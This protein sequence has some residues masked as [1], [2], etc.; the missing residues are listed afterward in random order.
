MSF[1]KTWLFQNKYIGSHIKNFSHLLLSGGKVSVPNEQHKTLCKYY[2]KDIINGNINYITEM[3]TSVFKFHMDIDLLNETPIEIETIL[4]Y[5]KNIQECIKQFISWKNI[6]N[7]T[8]AKKYMMIISISPKQTKNKNNNE[9]IKYGIHLNWPY[10]H[11]DTYIASIL[12]EGCIQYLTQIF[13]ERHDNN[14]W[15]DVIDKTVYT[16]NGLR[17]IFSDK[18]IACPNCKGKKNHGKDPEKINIC[19]VCQDVGKVPANRIYEILS[20]LD[21]N[22]TIMEKELLLL[23]TKSFENILKCVE[24]LSIRCFNKKTNVEIQEPFPKWYKVHNVILKVKTE[25]IDKKQVNPIVKHH[26]TETSEIKKKF[27]ILE[28]FGID[29][30]RYKDIEQF[31]KD[32][33]PS[34]YED[35]KII[36]ILLCGKKNSKTRSYI[37]R[38]D[39]KFC[40]N[41]Q[42]EHNSNH[43]YFIITPERMHQRCFCRC[44]IIRPSG[45]KCMNY[46]DKGKILST[47]LKEKLFPEL[48]ENLNEQRQ[49]IQYNPNKFSDIHPLEDV[50]ERFVKYF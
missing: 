43:I 44:D 25:K 29:D 14:K 7:E 41:I 45:I 12:R 10:L 9:Y 30:S 33:L 24:L 27:A 48:I 31:M 4:T 15:D 37:I 36:E 6:K 38:T 32:F 49:H 18:A 46:M 35:I 13:G 22:N 19:C 26:L 2:A 16:N 39:S 21:G 50:M 1:T 5:C 23:Q 40:Q 17:W 28:Q 8:N 3:R 34:D 47:K 42:D 20:I 11:V